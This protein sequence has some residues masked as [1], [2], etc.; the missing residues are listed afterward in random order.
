MNATDLKYLSSNTVS[1]EEEGTQRGRPA[2]ERYPFQKQH[3][4][5]KTHVLMKYSGYRVP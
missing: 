1:L 5:A 2:N 3:P 4:Q